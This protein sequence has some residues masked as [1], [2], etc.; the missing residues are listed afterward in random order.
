MM[1]SRDPASA[2]EVL[3]IL[4]V[5]DEEHIVNFLRMG[6]SYEGFNVAS[7]SDAESA[8]RLVES[9]H[10]HLVVLD[11]MLPGMDGLD[12]AEHLLRDPDLTIIMLTARDQV[13]D[14]IAGLNL[15]ADDYVVK[16]FDFDEL[17]ARIRAVV[18]RRMPAQSEILRAGPI[19]LDQA[20]REVT[21]ESDP[22]ELTLKEF[23]LL[24]LFLLHPRRVLPRHHILDRVWGYDFYGSE[25]NVEVYIGY[26]RR[27]L[28]D[29]GHQLIETV[30]GVG[31]RLNV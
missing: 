16:P 8:L 12:L 6:L 19:V 10:P 20:R 15:G 3:R 5:D 27:K 21:F 7:A 25:N 14:R 26:L 11:L 18:R 23:E 1:R 2:E 13:G 4:V 30:R 31:Y 9:F 24:R 22:V 29:D 17:V 28:R